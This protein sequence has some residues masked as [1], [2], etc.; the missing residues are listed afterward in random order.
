MARFDRAIATAERLI[1]RNGQAVTW[2]SVNRAPSSVAWKQGEA[3][4]V[5]YPVEVCFLPINQQMRQ[6]F[7]Y[8]RGTSEVPTGSVQGLMRGS[9]P[10]EPK[11][12]DV[13]IRDGETLRI[14]SI[15]LLSPNGQR[16]LYTIEFET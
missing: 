4:D 15:D 9:V 7:H 14:K 16:V 13:V 6:L 12:E 10:F 1:K 8:L 3:A 2:V 11:L 5:E